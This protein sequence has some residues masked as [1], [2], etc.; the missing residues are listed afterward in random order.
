M[1]TCGWRGKAVSNYMN[2]MAAALLA[3]GLSQALAQDA[4]KEPPEHVWRPQAERRILERLNASSNRTIRCDFIL[5][6]LPSASFTPSIAGRTTVLNFWRPSCGPCKPLLDELAALSRSA[7]RDVVILAAAEG[8]SPY[9][10][11]VAIDKVRQEISA[12]VRQHGVPFPVCGY[13]D[14]SQAKL[15]QAEGVPL[16]LFFDPSG[17][18]GRV[19][20]GGA[21]GSR[22]LKELQ[23]GWRP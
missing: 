6:A 21:E 17:R 8:E 16:T 5:N 9:G 23:A 2:Y 1:D 11:P 13:T 3:L 7:P 4:T 18:I 15:W 19:A 20:I 14:H 12:I 10:Q 22:A